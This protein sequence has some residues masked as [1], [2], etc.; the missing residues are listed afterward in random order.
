MM[1]SQ[2]K[3][4]LVDDHPIVRQGLRQVIEKES[5]LVICAEFSNGKELTVEIDQCQAD[6]L[7]LDVDMPLMNG[8]EVLRHLKDKNSDIK[9]ILLTFHSEVEFFNEAMRLGIMAY[10]LKECAVEDIVKAIRSVISGQTYISE[11]VNQTPDYHNDRSESAGLSALTATE[12]EILMMI[13]DYKTNKEI[14][15]LLFISPLTVKTHRRNISQKLNIIGSNAL[16][17]FALEN[18]KLL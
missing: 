4:I 11:R 10:V 1:P 9:V 8:F 18:K 13:A 16:M 5:D 12:R 14:G 2:Y 6:V 3:I 15:D 7:V 17:K